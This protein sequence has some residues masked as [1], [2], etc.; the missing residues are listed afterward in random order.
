MPPTE[1][2]EYEDSPKARAELLDFLQHT[3]ELRA[4]QGS[5]AKR[6]AHWWDEN[7]FAKLHPYRGRILRAD[8]RV[9]G[10]GGTIPAGYA[11]AGQQVPVLLA[12]TLRVDPAFPKAGLPMLLKMRKLSAEVPI[13]HTTPIPKLQHA[14]E[15]MG[16]VCEK[17]VRRRFYP[18]GALAR[19]S[20]AHKKWPMLDAGLTLIT[21]VDQARA[22]LRPWRSQDWL[23]KW[24]TIESLNWY[25]TTPTRQQRFLGVVDAQGT[26]H[27][28]LILSPRSARGI[29]AWDVVE[30]FTTRDTAV[31]IHALVGAL[32]RDPELLPGL[33]PLLTVASFP[34]DLTWD[35]TPSLM[36]REQ[37]VCHYFMLPNHLRGVPKR[38][39]MAEGDLVL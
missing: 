5:W 24:T 1:F 12:S 6:L 9:I 3:G 11:L 34:W 35:Q 27:S 22:L 30:S 28:Y 39:L 26:L 15:K 10:F 31:E 32:I 17:L 23:E 2:H 29:Q 16:A 8:G 36:A 18:M 33:R 25:L 4:G 38:T 37:H 13:F 19:L 21:R 14:L 7:P 20:R